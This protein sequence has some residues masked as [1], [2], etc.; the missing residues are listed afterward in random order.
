MRLY[1]VKISSEGKLPSYFFCKSLVT[2]IY[3]NSKSRIR[4]PAHL[5]T[6]RF[7]LAIE[8]ERLIFFFTDED[9]VNL[10]GN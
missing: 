7:A 5:I 9:S 6:D 1:I 4:T 10:Y 3:I 2:Y 8:I